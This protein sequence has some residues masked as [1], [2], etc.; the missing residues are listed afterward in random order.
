[1]TGV[2]MASCL[3]GAFGGIALRTQRKQ[4]A[5]KRDLALADLRRERDAQLEREN[6]AA[7]MITLAAGIAHEVASPLNV[8]GGW[9][10]QLAD[11]A[12]AS[13]KGRAIPAI[14]AQTERIRE[15]L[16]GFLRLARGDVPPL[17][18]IKPS[19]VVA[20][21]VELVEHRFQKAGVVL[22]AHAPD[23]LPAVRG[24]LRLL[25]H[26]LVN[27]L[28]NA[29]DAC[30]PGGAVEV[31]AS[32][33]RTDVSFIVSDDGIG[34]SPDNAARVI[35]PFFSTKAPG[36]G[37]GLGLAIATEIVKIHRGALTL[38]PREPCGTSA[39]IRLPIGARSGNAG[40]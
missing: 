30:M 37:S 34:I 32:A 5:L 12:D 38:A 17:E 25:E 29:C 6:R 19:A 36:E 23:D 31:R 2:L 8:I 1:V 26:A 16:S 27:L 15:V 11:G 14:L 4:D 9:A 13:R 18:E 22:S 3:V 33:D 21:A 7:T 35:E 10:E 39:S 28:L 40:A 20:A 24:D